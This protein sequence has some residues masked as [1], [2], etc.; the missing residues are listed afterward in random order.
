[1][2]FTTPTDQRYFEDYI[3]GHVHEFGSVKVEE[4]EVIAYAR[5]FDPQSFHIDAE[6]AKCSP[7]GGII[8][9]GWHTGCM[10]MQMYTNHYLSTVASLPSPGMDEVRWLKPVRPGDRLSVRLT[11]QDATRCRSKPDRGVV[12]ALIEVLNQNQEVVMRLYDIHMIR[13]RS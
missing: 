5:R 13:C 2:S 4:A 7:F 11:I 8:A 10:M 9:S 1:M 6:A 3:P 12:R